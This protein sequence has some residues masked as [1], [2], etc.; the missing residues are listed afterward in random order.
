VVACAVTSTW[1]IEGHRGTR[2]CSPSRSSDDESA[3][4]VGS[5]LLRLYPL[6]SITHPFR[7]S[8]AS[9]YHQSG[10]IWMHGL[11][12]GGSPECC[13]PHSAHRRGPVLEVGEG[14]GA[15]GLVLGG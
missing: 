3:R 1:A 9:V 5:D 11:R 10:S 4:C 15:V 14:S 7:F 13:R 12:L 6:V 8:S 2:N